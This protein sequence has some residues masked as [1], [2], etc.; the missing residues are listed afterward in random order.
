MPR[1]RTDIRPRHFA[2]AGLIGA[3]AACASLPSAPPAEIASPAVD[4][5]FSIGGR[6]SARHGSDGVAGA[7][8]WRHDATHDAIELSTP[9][10]QTIAQ[11]EGDAREVTVRLSDGRIERAPDWSRLTERAFGVTI[12]VE[13][14]SAWVRGIPRT[15]SRFDA[16]RDG[17]G[18]IALLRQQGWEIVYA[19]ADASPRPFRVSL[20]YPGAD[21][22]EVRVVID[23]WQ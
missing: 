11:L 7:F 16:E 1:R 22:V 3:L 15:D 23:R 13:G 9:L 10:G 5:A 18:R 14:L 12:P 4:A 2:L 6:I 19:Y 21:A 17:A 8:A 20:Q